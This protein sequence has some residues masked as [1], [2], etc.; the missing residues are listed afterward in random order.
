[1]VMVL[2]TIMTPVVCPK[3]RVSVSMTQENAVDTESI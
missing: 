3:V 1:M 2:W